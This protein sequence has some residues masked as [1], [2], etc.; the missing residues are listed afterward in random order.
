MTK[1]EIDLNTTELKVGDTLITKNGLEVVKTADYMDANSNT[2]LYNFVLD[3][4][5]TYYA[6]GYLVHNK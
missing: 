3:G 2:Q 4:D 6:N 5:H 1:L